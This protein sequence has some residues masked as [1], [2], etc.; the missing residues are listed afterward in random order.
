MSKIKEKIAEI[1]EKR[2]EAK[3]KPW[4]KKQKIV[5]LIVFAAVIIYFLVSSALS[6]KANVDFALPSLKIN[7]SVT[8]AVI[9]G[10]ALI[11]FFAFKI[12]SYIKDRKDGRK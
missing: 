12:C 1:K 9:L 5:F 2:L 11:G 6:N 10:L 7:I 3:N 8:D 4:S